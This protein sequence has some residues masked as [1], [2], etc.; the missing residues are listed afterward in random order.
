MRDKSKSPG[1]KASGLFVVTFGFDPRRS[2]LNRRVFFHTKTVTLVLDTR[3]HRAF[4]LTMDSR[5]K[6][7]NDKCGVSRGMS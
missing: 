7:E 4:Q 3:V 5:V 6:P 1:V 2:G